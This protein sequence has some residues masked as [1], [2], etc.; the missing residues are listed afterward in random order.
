MKLDPE[1]LFT[2][3]G[4][5]GCAGDDVADLFQKVLDTF[6]LNSGEAIYYVAT[7]TSGPG[8]AE[9]TGI[10]APIVQ[11]I[12]LELDRIGL[13]EH[14]TAVRGSWR[15]DPKDSTYMRACTG[16]GFIKEKRGKCDNCEAEEVAVPS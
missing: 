5:C 14:G 1:R 11:L 15:T 9:R 16:C 8:I 12:L 2:A 4:F 7:E 3:L 10:P 13:L 6:P